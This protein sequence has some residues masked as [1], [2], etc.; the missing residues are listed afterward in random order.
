[1]RPQSQVKGSHVVQCVGIGEPPGEREMRN[2]H[3]RLAVVALLSLLPTATA[4][5]TV[6]LKMTDTNNG[7][8]AVS[9]GSGLTFPV[10]V[11]VVASGAGTANATT[12]LDYYF[13][14]ISGPAN[15]V[16]SISSRDSTGSAYP[17]LNTPPDNAVAGEVMNPRNPSDLGGSTSPAGTSKANGTFLAAKYLLLVDPAAPAG[18]YLIGTFSF[19]GTGF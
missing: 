5:G 19:P 7:T 1:M 6:I 14:Q 4:L 17:D 3:S 13:Q 12:G 11:S 15:G 16:F 10:T 8:G 18:T 2:F 9:V